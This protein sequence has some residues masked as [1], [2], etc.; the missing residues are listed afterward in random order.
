[1]KTI[2]CYG[3]SNTWGWS[4]SM[5][6]RYDPDVRWPGVL[7]KELGSEYHIVEE[8]LPGRTTVWDDPIE[9]GCDGKSYLSPCL[10][11]H[12]PID[13][14]IIM[15]GTN[16]LKVRFSVPALDIAA[17]IEVLVSIVKHSQSGQD[18]ESPKILV[19]SP[20]AINPHQDRGEWDVYEGGI[21]KSQ[22][23]GKALSLVANEQ[24]V[25]FFDAAEVIQS[26]EIDGIHMDPEAHL[27]LGKK[28][29]T[30]CNNILK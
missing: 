3:D 22:K 17:G 13:L 8:G 18:G 29:A 25:Y 21:E 28:L 26:S 23:L 2:L 7:S 6:E 15:L 4:P 1:M 14:V 24:N 19:V 10:A 11:S 5:L 20:P 27:I 16:D 30:I 9:Q 12:S